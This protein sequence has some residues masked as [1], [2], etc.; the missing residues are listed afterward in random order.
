[1][2]KVRVHLGGHGLARGHPRLLCGTARGSGVT[3]LSGYGDPGYTLETYAFL[4][5]EG[6]HH[7]GPTDGLVRRSDLE[8]VAGRSV[9]RCETHVI[10]D[11]ATSVR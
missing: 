7:I 3:R 8:R 4:R 5:K 1:M 2:E 9:R 11:A 10:R 6:F